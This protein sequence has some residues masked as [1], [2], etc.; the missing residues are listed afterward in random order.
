[1]MPFSLTLCAILPSCSSLVN[2][3]LPVACQEQEDRNLDSLCSDLTKIIHT[4]FSH[5][6]FLVQ[7]FSKGDFF[8]QARATC[9]GGWYFNTSEWNWC[10][11]YLQ[12]SFCSSKFIFIMM[13]M[14]VVILVYYMM[15]KIF[16]DLVLLLR[17]SCVL[18]SS[19][20]FL[21]KSREFPV[22]VTNQVYL[23]ICHMFIKYVTW[24]KMH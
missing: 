20:C 9:L 14:K 13:Y 6:Q 10:C 5:L 15:Y 12:T 24:T 21:F 8:F 23:S 18:Q 3:M 7:S 2:Q 11:N 17:Q 22:F 1:M 16:M 4:F 19:N